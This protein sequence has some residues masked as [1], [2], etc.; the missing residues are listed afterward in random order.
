LVKQNATSID[1]IDTLNN[2]S[3]KH[4]KLPEIEEKIR[5]WTISEI[6]GDIEK[7]ELDT[8]FIN[9]N[10]TSTDEC[11]DIANSWLGNMG[12][13]MQSKIFFNRKDESYFIFSHPYANYMQDA[14]DVQFF[15]TKTP[16]SS[17]AYYRA[18]PSYGREERLKARFAVSVTPKFSF[19]FNADYI[20]GRGMYIAQSTKDVIGNFWMGYRG[21]KYIFHAVTGLNHF[22]NYEN[23]GIKNDS[24]V[25]Y[26]ELQPTR[27]KAQNMEVNIGA[28]KKAQ[29]NLQN[30]YVLFTQKFRTGKSEINTED[31]TE[32]FIP[33]INFIHTAKYE[34]NQ[35]KYSEDDTTS[36]YIGQFNRQIILCDSL[37]R[38]KVG[39]HS[40]SNTLGVELTEDFNKKGK[41]GLT[42][43][44]THE[45]TKYQ[46]FADKKFHYTSDNDLVVG[47]ILSKNNGQHFNY[48]ASGD[49]FVYGERI[50]EFNLSGNIATNF[51]VGKKNLELSGRVFFKNATPNRFIQHYESNYFTWDNENFK[52]EKKLH[53]DV[54]FGIPQWHLWLKGGAENITDF[55]F[56]NTKAVPEQYDK[57]IQ[58]ASL[59]LRK[60]FH[61][62]LLHLENEFTYQKSSHEDALP[63]PELT[64]YNNL[65]FMT[66]I[67]KVLT[68]QIGGE[69]HYHTA[70][71][72]QTYNPATGLFYNSDKK[73]GNYPILNVYANVHLKR[74]R[75]FVMYY[76][77]NF[78]FS[79]NN[80]FS[81][82]SYPINPGML[83]LG[84]SWNFYD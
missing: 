28:E 31:S 5:V 55:I 62:W 19:G 63:L 71:K 48:N 60:D 12:S 33:I 61:V 59:T 11:Y 49:V 50:G 32:T 53:F 21:K 3:A 81:T 22:K 37:T 79:D 30:Q 73:I 43:Y 24:V 29:T 6:T 76:H 77:S 18:G 64:T 58:V 82:A 10:Q 17:I 35:R 8:A 4:N 16:F 14:K 54:R 75:F 45:Y 39:Y 40:L 13:P 74:V 57:N 51:N 67:F 80:Y 38:D 83:K 56:F 72:A 47:G 69:L 65:Y 27:I 46:Y 42:G 52:N 7:S 68:F 20:Y 15:D 41:F 1:I 26:P 78:N 25:L 70:Y 66:T 23:G 44:V 9:F 84:L 34:H 36:F 2:D